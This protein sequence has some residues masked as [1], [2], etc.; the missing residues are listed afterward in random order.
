MSKGNKGSSRKPS[1]PANL[2]IVQAI[3]DFRAIIAAATKGGSSVIN[4]QTALDAL[5]PL[6]QDPDVLKY[7]SDASERFDHRRYNEHRLTWGKETHY[8]ASTA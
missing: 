6:L 3:H 7:A 5:I 1:N 2:S 4:A 8:K